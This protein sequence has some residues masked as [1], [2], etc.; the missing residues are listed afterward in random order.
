MRVRAAAV[1]M[2]VL[3]C[4]GSGSGDGRETGSAAEAT[5]EP[6]IQREAVRGTVH[7]VRM[8]GTQDGRFAYEPVALTIRVGDRVRWVNV[9]GGPHNVAFH[10]DRIPPGA[11]AF[12]NAAMARRIGDLSGELLVAANA[13]YE[14]AFTGAPRGTY[15]YFCT[16][17]QMLGMTAQLTVVP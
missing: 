11:R 17:H 3:A 8:L 7:E 6:N 4:G 5:P 14:I 9:S 1:A 2:F 12:L 16:P 13:V 10:P 15:E